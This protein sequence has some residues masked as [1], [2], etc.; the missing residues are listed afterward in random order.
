MSRGLQD[1]ITGEQNVAIG[2][3][4]ARELEK[5]RGPKE[6]EKKAREYVAAGRKIQALGDQEAE[7]AR[8]GD[9]EAFIELI[10]REDAL[11]KGSDAD[12]VFEGC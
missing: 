1:R 6:D 11:A 4:A 10:G 5:V 8:S 2:R 7:A 12:P 3:E 9:R